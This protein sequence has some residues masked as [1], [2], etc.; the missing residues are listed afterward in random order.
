[1]SYADDKVKQKLFQQSRGCNSK[2]NDPIWPALELIP[3]FI[4]VHLICKFQKNLLKTEGVMVMT[5]IF[6]LYVYETLWL[7]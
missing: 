1:M 4:H 2:I 6:Q 5:N 7:P 3:D